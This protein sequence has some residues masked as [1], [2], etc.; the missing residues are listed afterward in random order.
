MEIFRVQ[1]CH[2]SWS[3]QM[4]VS[5]FHSIFKATFLFLLFS[6]HLYGF[7][8]LTLLPTSMYSRM[9]LFSVVLLHM[10]RMQNCDL[11]WSCRMLIW[12][13]VCL[14]KVRVK[15]SSFFF[16][17]F[18]SPLWPSKCTANSY[19]FTTEVG[20]LLKIYLHTYMS[21]FLIP[22]TP[23]DITIENF[24]PKKFLFLILV[25]SWWEGWCH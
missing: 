6:F 9:K 8:N 4:R 1:D 7:H 19:A 21:E 24:M 18:L 5:F 23:Y 14:F 13:F 11:P 20:L 16:T 15:P 10:F 2:L 22:C 12:F 3:Y 25:N 17:D